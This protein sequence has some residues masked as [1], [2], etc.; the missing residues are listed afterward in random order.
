MCECASAFAPAVS[1]V[2]FFFLCC[3]KLLFKCVF[4]FHPPLINGNVSSLRP[5]SFSLSLTHS[6]CQSI[7]ANALLY[8]STQMQFIFLILNRYFPHIFCLDFPPV[9]Y[10]KKYTRQHFAFS[11]ITCSKR[12]L[13]QRYFHYFT[14]FQAVYHVSRYRC[15]PFAFHLI[16][17]CNCKWIQLG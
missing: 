15:R 12:L 7:N 2:L 6:L 10:S 9:V 8:F 11:I 16:Q 5:P 1:N 3:F 13:L 14:G 4:S 17:L